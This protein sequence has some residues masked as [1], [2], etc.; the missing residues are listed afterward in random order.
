MNS[1]DPQECVDE[2]HK[3]MVAMRATYTE[4]AELA[5]YKLKDVGHTW[6]KMCQD[7]RIL[8]G[9]PIS[10]EFFKKTFLERFF[11]REMRDSKVEEFINLK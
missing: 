1:E 3:I 8:G 6:C 4:K 7:S 11:P 5:S 2:V 10:W 9:F